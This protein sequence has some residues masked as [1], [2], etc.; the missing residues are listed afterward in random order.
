MHRAFQRGIRHGPGHARLSCGA[1]RRAH[2][3]REHRRDS[4]WAD[5]WRG[6]GGRRQGGS[7]R[8]QRPR[9]PRRGA[10][11]AATT[12]VADPTRLLAAERGTLEHY[13]PQLAEA[14]AG[15]S[16]LELEA[17]DSGAIDTFRDAGGP[18]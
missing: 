8:G 3:A 17:A 13:L 7:R 15:R 9:P 4:G 1:D 6:G 2:L 12:A 11:M 16:L 10:V 18:G 5:R 14:L